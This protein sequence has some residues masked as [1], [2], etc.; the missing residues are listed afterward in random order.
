MDETF[1]ERLRERI[2]AL[3]PLC[4]GVD[5]SRELLES[6]DRDDTVDGVEFFARATLDSVVGTVAAIKPQ[7]AFFERFGSAGYRVLEQLISDA[8]DADVMVVADAKRGDFAI[9]NAGYA[10]AWLSERS[11][12]RV[13]A[14]TAS[15]YLG[16]DAL[17]P[18]FSLAQESARGVFVLVATSNP[19]GR[20]LQRARTPEG[21]RVEDL[22]L[23]SISELN[24][25]SDGAGS[26]GVVIGATR[27]APEF[28]LAHLGGPYLVPGV[29]AQGAS[30]EDVARLFA[31]CPKHTVLV[32]VARSVLKAG[33]ERNAL[34]DAARRWRDDLN[35][36]LA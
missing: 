26:F 33:P 6:W 14:V 4:V 27:D 15:P 9:T 8:R 31:R 32:N 35:Q 24:K 12:L 17:A 7:V 11:P 28:D 25:R 18:L 2:R 36:A 13:D 23:R 29:G 19:E 34:R 30:A 22:V 1:G 10:E 5:P 20:V 3:G 16:V 21:E